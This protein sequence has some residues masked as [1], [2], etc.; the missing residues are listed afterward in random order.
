MR[1]GIKHMWSYFSQVHLIFF[2]NLQICALIADC[3]LIRES[4]VILFQSGGKIMPT[5]HITTRP[6][7]GFS[8]LTTVLHGCIPKNGRVT[9]TYVQKVYFRAKNND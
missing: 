7:P 2:E 6:P 9:H 8:D 5:D 1:H 4:R 3:L